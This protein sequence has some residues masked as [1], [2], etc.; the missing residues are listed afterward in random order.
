VKKNS[1]DLSQTGLEIDNG[2][3]GQVDSIAAC[4]S[5]SP[6]SYG[7]SF[8]RFHVGW[9]MF[10]VS[11]YTICYQ[12]FKSHNVKLKHNLVYFLFTL[13]YIMVTD[14]WHVKQVMC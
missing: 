8:A 3:K 12:L 4:Y 5:V 6:N 10:Y 2:P 11:S 1:N 9:V 7:D 14:Q 13:V